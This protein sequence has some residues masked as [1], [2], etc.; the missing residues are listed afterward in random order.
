MIPTDMKP[1]TLTD[2]L[3]LAK[4]LPDPKTYKLKSINLVPDVRFHKN[5]DGT[6][7]IINNPVVVDDAARA[8]S[9]D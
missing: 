7:W 4:Q 8:A 3:A 1:V 5:T 2:L 9:T 6:G